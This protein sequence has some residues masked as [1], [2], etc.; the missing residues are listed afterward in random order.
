MTSSKMGLGFGSKWNDFVDLQINEI[1][2]LKR[3][4]NRYTVTRITENA[5]QEQILLLDW[6]ER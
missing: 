6:P 5:C 1:K 2:L 3:N 4:L